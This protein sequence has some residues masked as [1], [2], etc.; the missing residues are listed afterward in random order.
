MSITTYSGLLDRLAKMV[1]F[2]ADNTGD[3]SVGVLA[4]VISM[5]EF[6]IYREI[7]TSMNTN[8]F[9][10]SDT[11]TS[12]AMALPSD[13][14][15]AYTVH[16]GGLPL[17]PVSPEFLQ[18]YM[19]ANPSGECKYFANVSNTLR[20]GPAVANGTQVQ[21]YYYCSL[22]DLSEATLPTNAL[23]LAAN[24]LFLF[25]CMVEAAPLYGFQNQIQ[26]WEAKYQM[27]RD[28]LNKE[29]ALNAYSSGRLKRRPSTILMG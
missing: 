27:T 10:V 19:D 8:A 11:V 22:P 7:R 20:F 17:E 29:H 4:A 16:F 3:A 15:A 28:A 12:N 18:Q 6:R 25:A 13:F 2:D 23:F 1:T 9:G 14:K 5:A 24:D 26:L 21:G